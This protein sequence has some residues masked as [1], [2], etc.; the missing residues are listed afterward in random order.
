MGCL[1]N[2]PLNYLKNIK[3]KFTLKQIFDYLKEN[4]LLKIIR[5]NN[6]LQAR[7]NKDIHDYKNYYQ[8]EIEIFPI[9]NIEGKFINIS[10]ES[11]FHI[12]FN[13]SKEETKTNKFNLKD[14]IKKIKVIIDKD[15]ES[16]KDLF[17]DCLF[18][19][20]INFIKFNRNDIK[21]ISTLFYNCKSLEEIDL[22]NFKT[23]SVTD[24]S[25]LFCECSSLKEINL[26]N[27]NTNNV[28]N[29]SWMFAECSSLEKIDLNNFNTN[30]VTDLSCMFRGC[31]SLKEINLSN[32]NT[33]NVI[34]MSYMFS[35][36]LSIKEL[37]LSKFRFTQITERTG[38]FSLTSPEIKII[39]PKI[40]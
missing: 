4:K 12:Y 32:F 29:M 7:L 9:E 19:K 2:K 33:N 6:A 5:Y 15:L 24:M 21:N 38:M 28:N 34:D 25:W 26:S 36:C 11:L 17:R 10:N 8:I 3:S 23:N 30:K 14:K 1:F 18:I 13:D 16:L 31:S 35:L 37:N 39:H 20:K 27:F 40:D 22:S